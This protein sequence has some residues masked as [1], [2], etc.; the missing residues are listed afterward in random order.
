M[1]FLN[2]NP[3]PVMETD[4]LKLRKLL[5]EDATD[6]FR[7]RTHPEVLRY[8]DR[9]PERSVK[10]VFS[11]ID[12]IDME[13]RSNTS[14]LWAIS[15]A[16]SDRLIGTICFWRIDTYHHRA[17]V[18][19]LLLPEYWGQGLMD[20][21][22]KRIIHYG[23]ED[24]RLHTIEANINPDNKASKN[25]LVRNGFVTEGYFRE[26]YYF[27]GRYLDEEVLSLIHRE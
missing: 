11:V 22:L 8:L 13:I 16:G 18:G 3:F 27:D 12:N 24:I 4:R 20:E 1:I 10:E 17:E 9:Q 2:F 21:A 19:Y 26:S 6:F 5:H 7:L 14:V 15:P 23:W 25:L